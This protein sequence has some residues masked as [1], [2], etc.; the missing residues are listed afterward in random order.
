MY[1]E[2]GECGLKSLF[3]K[4]KISSK[5][6]NRKFSLTLDEF[7]KITSGNCTY[8]GEKPNKVSASEH[9]RKLETKKYTSYLYNGI[10]RVNSNKGYISSNVVPCCHWCN[11]I[12]RERT[13][14]ELKN[15]VTRIYN[16]G[17]IEHSRKKV[18]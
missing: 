2:P 15:H 18:H 8:C 4:Y 5:K 9:I 3:S 14:E 11:T 16:H 7:K 13:V 12:K 17:K 10:D 6:E 1:K